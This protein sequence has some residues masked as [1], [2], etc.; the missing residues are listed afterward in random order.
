MQIQTFKFITTFICLTR[1]VHQW[2]KSLTIFTFEVLRRR[3]FW[4]DVGLMVLWVWGYWCGTSLKQTKSKDLQFKEHEMKQLLAALETAN[5]RLETQ[6]NVNAAIM[7]KK[8]EVRVS[9]QELWERIIS[10]QDYRKEL[11]EL[12]FSLTLSWTRRLSGSFWRLRHKEINRDRSFLKRDGYTYIWYTY[13]NNL[14][15]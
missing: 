1:V 2:M 3:L 4:V 7:R 10:S 5:H 6:Q 13:D 9:H 14:Q 12:T 15:A 8:E 11:V